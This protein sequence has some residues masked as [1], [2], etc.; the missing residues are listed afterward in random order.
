MTNHAQETFIK[1]H[2]NPEN[3]NQKE[4]VEE[5]ALLFSILIDDYVKTAAKE[6]F[7]NLPYKD[8]SVLVFDDKSNDIKT[9]SF[10]GFITTVT[11]EIK[12]TFNS[13]ELTTELEHATACYEKFASH[14][15]LALIQKRFM[16]DTAKEANR[17]AGVA[18]K[19]ADFAKKQAK[20]AKEMSNAMVTNFVTILGVF[21]TII[22]TVFGGMQIIS[23]TTKLL[24][25]DLNLATLFLVLSFISL[26]IIL[27][28]WMLFS[29]I[30]NLKKDVNSNSALIT[31]ITVLSITIMLSAAYIIFSGKDFSQTSAKVLVKDDK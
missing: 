21:A 16:L 5:T 11:E 13:Y 3:F 10:N 23:A 14:I 17:V 19:D 27:I 26:L 6:T 28:L 22:I 4:I 29:F 2:L 18:R 30:I 12:N 9:D 24:Q 7:Y 1:R 8:I 15:E 31:A 25:T 20:K